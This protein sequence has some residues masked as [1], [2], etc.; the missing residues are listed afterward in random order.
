M[1]H[2]YQAKLEHSN[3]IYVNESVQFNNLSLQTYN[4]K[5]VE[6]TFSMPAI[7]G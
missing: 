5:G 7:F 4:I 2:L 3:A 1:L 6:I